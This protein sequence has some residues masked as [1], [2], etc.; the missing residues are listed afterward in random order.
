MATPYEVLCQN[1]WDERNFFFDQKAECAIFLDEFRQ[2]FGTFMGLPAER[3]EVFPPDGEIEENE[4]P[5]KRKFYTSYG[6]LK[7]KDD[8]LWHFRV[9]IVVESAPNV[10]PKGRLVVHMR[11]KATPKD[12]AVLVE[13]SGNSFER[14]PRGKSAKRDFTRL[15][16]RV[17]RLMQFLLGGTKRF[18]E[19]DQAKFESLRPFEKEGEE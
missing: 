6:A 3:V 14:F 8:A 7:I 18:L 5:K 19:K 13:G 2:A 4:D 9:G 17:V 1:Y 15:S 16:N 10:W 11:L 12:F